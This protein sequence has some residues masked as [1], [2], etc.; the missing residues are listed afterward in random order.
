MTIVRAKNREGSVLIRNAMLQD[1]RL[2]PAVLGTLVYLHAYLDASYKDLM[3]RFD[4]GRDKASACLKAAKDYLA[5]HG[6]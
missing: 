6:Y 3:R 5:I 4:I 2:S 1:G